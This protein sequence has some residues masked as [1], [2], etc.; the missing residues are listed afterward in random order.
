[1]ALKYLSAEEKDEFYQSKFEYFKS[2]SF[3]VVVCS[4]L[5][6]LTYFVSDCQ[7]FGRFAWETLLPR[8]FIL[9]P[10]AVFLLI[11]RRVK[12][13]KIIV[14]MMYLI[15]HC[16]MWCT[17]WAIYYLPIKQHANEGFIIMHLMFQALAF[18][19]PIRYSMFCHT[20][21]IAD[22]VI[23]NFFNHYESFS[24]MLSL[25][26]PCLLG[27]CVVSYVMEKAYLDQYRTKK[28]LENLLTRDPLTNAY[29]RKKFS[30]LCYENTSKLRV[31]D[32]KD[33][34]VLIL[35][36]DYFKKVNDDYGHDVGDKVL[37]HV[38]DVITACIRQTDYVV[39][40]GG[41]E[42]VVV[43]AE[44]TLE[45]AQMVAE[46]IRSMVELSDGSIPNITLSVGVSKYDGDDYHR[47][48][49]LADMALYEA[50]ASGKNKVMVYDG[51]AMRQHN[52]FSEVE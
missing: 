21:L 31:S 52:A 43:L 19:A 1:M 45:G 48:I 37:K 2:Y 17:I 40:W 27:I 23:S 13:Y 5:A 9:L 29:N 41:E 3:W 50:K 47:A 11:N 4:A 16:I 36:I 25:G 44:A 26:I 46:R 42:F 24:L 51:N 12:S 10:L 6:S 7:L 30:E 14:P 15:L 32:G 18:C 22:I 28:S 20:L 8:S 35:D 38:V 33:T 39:R 49:T 34:Y